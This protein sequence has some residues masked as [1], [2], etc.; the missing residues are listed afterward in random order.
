MNRSGD[1]MEKDTKGM[2]STKDTSHMNRP[3]DVSES[4]LEK[5]L[6]GIA[7]NLSVNQAFGSNETQSEASFTSSKVISNANGVKESRGGSSDRENENLGN[8]LDVG[9]PGD[10]GVSEERRDSHLIDPG[11]SAGSGSKK[12]SLIDRPAYSHENDSDELRIS[13]ATKVC[14]DW[15]GDF[16]QKG[17]SKRGSHADPSGDSSDL[18]P[19]R[20]SYVRGTTHFS[21]NESKRDSCVERTSTTNERNE[22][23]FCINR[24]G[25]SSVKEVKRGSHMDSSP[26][27]KEKD[28]AELDAGSVSEN[29]AAGVANVDSSVGFEGRR[30]SYMERPRKGSYVDGSR[31]GSYVEGSRKGS[32]VDGSRRGSYG[33]GSRKGSYV[34]G[35]RRGSY[36]EG[37]RKGSYEEGSR[38]GS[39]V[40]G[41]RKGSYVEG[42]RK[43][44]YV[45][46]SRRGSYMDG[47]RTGSYAEGSGRGSYM[48]RSRKDSHLSRESHLNEDNRKEASYVIITGDSNEENRKKGSF[49]ISTD[50]S[51]ERSG[52]KASQMDRTDQLSE[53]S[54]KAGSYMGDSGETRTK[55]KT[56]L[57]INRS[58]DLRGSRS[59]TSSHISM[60]SDVSQRK[61]SASSISRSGGLKESGTGKTSHVSRTDYSGESDGA[62]SLVGESGKPGDLDEGKTKKTSLVEEESDSRV[63]RSGALKGDASDKLSVNQPGDT[64]ENDAEENACMNRPSYPGEGS[65]IEERTDDKTKLSV[66]GQENAIEKGAVRIS[67]SGGSISS[68]RNETRHSPHLASGRS[69]SSS[70]NE[71]GHPPHLTSGGNF[72][73]ND[74]REWRLSKSTGGLPMNKLVDPNGKDSKELTG[75]RENRISANSSGQ[76]NEGIPN[77]SSIEGE[78]S[79]SVPNLSGVSGDKS[80]RGAFTD[81]AIPSSGSGGRK[82]SHMNRTGDSNEG[83]ARETFHMNGTGDSNEGTA[84][85]TFHMNRAGDSNEGT[86]RETFHMNGTGDSNEGTARETPHMNEADNFEKENTN[87][88]IVSISVGSKESNT[89]GVRMS[90]SG[91]SK[92]QPIGGVG[93]SDGGGGGKESHVEGLSEGSY[94]E[95]SKKGSYVQDTRKGSH[96]DRDDNWSEK[97]RRTGSHAHR[98]DSSNEPKESSINNSGDLPKKGE[99]KDSY[100]NRSGDYNEGNKGEANG[101][102][103]PD[104]S[105][106]ESTNELDADGSTKLTANTSGHL[107]KNNA[108]KTSHLNTPNDSNEIDT[109]KDSCFEKP[110]RFSESGSRE[111]S[112]VVKSEGGE[113]ANRTVDPNGSDPNGSDPNGRDSNER[114]SNERG[115]TEACINSAGDTNGIT[116]EGVP[117]VSGL[118]DVSERK[119]KKGSLIDRPD[120]LNEDHSKSFS[121]D[122]GGHL[123]EAH[124]NSSV[125]NG[126]GKLAEREQHLHTTKLDGAEEM[127]ETAS[128]SNGVDELAEESDHQPSFNKSGDA[129]KTEDPTSQENP[130]TR[131]NEVSQQDVYTGK[132]A[133]ADEMED[134]TLQRTGGSSASS[135]VR[136]SQKPIKKLREYFVSG[137]KDS[138]T[139]KDSTREASGGLSERGTNERGNSHHFKTPQGKYKFQMNMKEEEINELQKKLKDEFQMLHEMSKKKNSLK[140][141]LE[142]CVHVECVG[143]A[144]Q[145]I[146]EEQYDRVD[147]K[148]TL[149]G[150]GSE[151]RS[152]GDETGKAYAKVHEKVYAKVHEKVHAKGP[153][154]DVQDESAF[155]DTR[156]EEA[157]DMSNF[158]TEM[159]N[160]EMKKLRKWKSLMISKEHK[161][162][163]LSSDV[164]LWCFLNFIKLK[165]IVNITELSV[166]FQ[167]KR[168]NI[169]RKLKE[170][171]E[172]DMIQGVMDTEENYIYLSQEEVTKLCV[173]ILSIEKIKT[174]EDFVEICNKVIS[175]S[176]NDQ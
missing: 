174:H 50:D 99:R 90:R 39:Y 28:A 147:L 86:A 63:S 162:D 165:K 55:E 159:S 70:R 103:G 44:S 145:A 104:D 171:E 82:T 76:S 30:G 125:M 152:E 115:S 118:A 85:E 150:S 164:L 97:N 1:L 24:S 136:E 6:V 69:V 111:T 53:T 169:R 79:L 173:E 130:A 26:D 21:E 3:D 121:T 168:E 134:P 126:N 16:I 106:E 54:S 140:N 149:S 87:E 52:R 17:T 155:E 133:D 163:W 94:V 116:S 122:R 37:Y 67:L 83:T 172:H 60:E 4:S 156:P 91:R 135:A 93:D 23:H 15:S 88:S 29:C 33:E 56:V 89:E 12:E 124:D 113:M 61:G 36:A 148:H 166:K 153:L 41:P 142:N 71:T 167:T 73:E 175:L 117:Y 46:G 19:T 62:A 48:E 160:R 128:P 146:D 66:K 42:S 114:D 32:Y 40:D 176:I 119:T 77:E 43:G 78:P 68:S 58:G 8:D 154:D 80:N 92:G 105:K 27:S 101:V 129:Y 34:D 100:M 137:K 45:E 47:P 25:D 84:R 35:S 20:G 38:K 157:F 158:S 108:K 64:P 11:Y 102:K 51:N 95:R 57:C 143:S 107:V 141:I 96:I 72:I 127:N 81:M 59:R 131:F 120:R 123:D 14:A 144:K 110:I 13:N 109:R 31:K 75:D 170:L 74:L 2:K 7:T 139:L 151:S 132:L 10:A 5:P 138:G 9:R 18:I 98:V 22:L 112:H 65:L 49:M 161:D